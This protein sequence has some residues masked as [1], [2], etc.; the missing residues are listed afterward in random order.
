MTR[1]IFGAVTL[2][3]LLVVLSQAKAQEHPDTDHDGISDDVEQALLLQFAPQMFVSRTDCAGSPA[4]FVPALGKP[5]IAAADGTLYGQ[6]RPVGHGIPRI[7]VHYFH[8][9]SKDC[10]EMGHRLDA[11]HVSVL[12]G[13][14]ALT[15]ASNWRAL[16]WYAASHE[17]TVCDASQITRASTLDAESHGPTVW[18]SAGKHASFLTEQLCQHGC[19]GDRCVAMSPLHVQAI[20]NLGEAAA[21][22]NGIAWLQSAEWPLAEKMTRTDFPQART[23]R[24]DKLPPTDIAWANPEKRPAQAAILGANAGLGGVAAGARATDTA[25]VIAR[26][27][28]GDAL[29]TATRNTR[30]ALSRAYRSARGAM[31]AN[32]KSAAD[33]KPQP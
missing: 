11:E 5:T 2:G 27:S 8:L 3:C 16:Y 4:A 15:S 20:L 17:N 21:P 9:W 29:G 6:V 1:L 32:A 13:G 19:G 10:G 33:E 7:E 12:L 26:R 28:T 25:S 23:S 24:L 14:G 31:G 18:V 22:M 30:H